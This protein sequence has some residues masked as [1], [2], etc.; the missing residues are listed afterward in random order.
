MQRVHTYLAHLGI[1]IMASQ[2]AKQELTNLCAPPTTVARHNGCTYIYMLMRHSCACS[3]HRVWGTRL[4]MFYKSICFRIFGMP[5]KLLLRRQRSPQELCD[6]VS[7]L[8]I[9]VRWG[10]ECA[11]VCMCNSAALMVV[12]ILLLLHHKPC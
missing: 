3:R 6:D 10:H 2:Q 9:S 8:S 7:L 11:C 4:N 5:V 12:I 1:V